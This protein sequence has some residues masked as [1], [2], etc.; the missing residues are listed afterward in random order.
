[1]LRSLV[2]GY[3]VTLLRITLVLSEGGRLVNHVLGKVPG[4]RKPKISLRSFESGPVG[5]GYY[6][7]RVN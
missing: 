1:M 7:L 4:L 5:H 3:S 2:D 6:P